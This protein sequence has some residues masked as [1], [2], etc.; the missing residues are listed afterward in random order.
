MT[1]DDQAA[2]PERPLELSPERFSRSGRPPYEMID[3]GPNSV[4]I[5]V[6]D[7]LGRAPLPASTRKRCVSSAIIAS[8]FGVISSPRSVCCAAL[9][10]S[11]KHHS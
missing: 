10:E 2:H 4:R 6:Y 9:P 11:S 8:G 5:V 1:A 3:I 7:E